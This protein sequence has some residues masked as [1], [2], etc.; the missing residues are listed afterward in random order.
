MPESKST[1]FGVMKKDLDDK[2]G[3][4]WGFLSSKAL[5]KVKELT[6]SIYNMLLNAIFLASWAA[7]QYAIQITILYFNVFETI[8]TIWLSAF[9]FTFAI[10]TF[11]PVVV[12]IFRDL[13][14]IFYETR[15][16]IHKER[17]N[18]PFKA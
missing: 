14:I 12:R 7:I 16:A 15:R 4:I 18:L 6:F 17:E 1:K 9:R 2:S 3:K 5:N 13:V 8:N 11:I 10:S